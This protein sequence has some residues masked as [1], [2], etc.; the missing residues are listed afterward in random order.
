VRYTWKATSPAHT[1]LQVVDAH[2]RV[3]RSWT[4][5]VQH[6]GYRSISW[7]GHNREGRLVRPGRYHFRVRLSEY[8]TTVFG[9]HARVRVQAG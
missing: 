1:T 7:L 6:A 3:V 4:L 2:G 5:K 9:G 8:G